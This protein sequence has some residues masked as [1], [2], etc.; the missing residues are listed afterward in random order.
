[1]KDQATGPAPDATKTQAAESA[2]FYLREAVAAIDA[3]FGDGYARDHP[4]L[5][6]S[7]VQASA[8]DGAVN[9]GNHTSAE[10]VE[11]IRTASRETNLT[12]LKLKPKLFG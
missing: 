4:E 3:T 12:L 11:T 5:V 10:I 8:I 1:M 2:A 6:A 7:L 9:A